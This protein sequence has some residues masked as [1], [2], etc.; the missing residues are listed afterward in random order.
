MQA[1]KSPHTGNLH[2]IPVALVLTVGIVSALILLLVVLLTVTATYIFQDREFQR[3]VVDAP[4]TEL[5][6]IE[7]EQ[8]A[9]LSAGPIWIDK[10]Q[11]VV[12]IPIDLAI[13]RYAQQQQE[14]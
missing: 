14:R 11:G 3:K 8:T 9:V 6:R 13:T 5:N 7:A 12:Q 10:E 1:D 2:G 4:F